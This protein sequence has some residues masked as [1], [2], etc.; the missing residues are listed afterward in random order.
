MWGIGVVVR[1]SDGNVIATT[2]QSVET[3]QNPDIG[4]ALSVR[5]AIQFALDMGFF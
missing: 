1:D 2:T 5:L 3:L 4:E